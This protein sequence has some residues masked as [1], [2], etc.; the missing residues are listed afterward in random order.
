MAKYRGPVCKLCRRERQALYL[1]GERCYTAKCPFL[2]PK[3]DPR[4]QLP[5]PPGPRPKFMRRP[6]EF[7]LQLREKQKARKIY[8]VS[9]GQFKG[10]SRKAEEMKG[11]TG[12]NLLSLLERRLDNV[13]LR[14][15]FATSH[16][17][18]RQLVNHRHFQVNGRPVNIP[19]YLVK[20]GDVIGV[21]RESL[22]ASFMQN[23]RAITSARPV[24]AWLEREPEVGRGRVVTLP[25]REHI[26]EAINEQLVVN[27]YSR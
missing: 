16:R 26:S 7:G 20:E 22:E 18:A 15:G 17:Q 5:L 8:W 6:T 27:F 14:L 3:K 19:S 2:A 25:R 13:V 4:E 23:I 12:E 9:G 10:Y 1:K 24:P 11:I 21:Q